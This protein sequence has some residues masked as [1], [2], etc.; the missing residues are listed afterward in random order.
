MSYLFAL[1]C[2]A[3]VIALDQLS[4]YWIVLQYGNTQNYTSV[5]GGLINI[6]HVENSGAAWSILAGR[7]W[8]LVSISL[9]VMVIC[10]F[11]LVKKTF[12]SKWMFWAVS[13]ILGGGIGNLIDRIFRG[14]RVVDFIEFGF[15]DFPVFN[16]ADI[17]V[18][19]GAIMILGA[20]VV[21]II[22][23]GKKKKAGKTE[24]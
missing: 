18:T 13:L 20:F 10:V 24:S 2:S 22:R 11:M 17:A 15:V 7:T 14:G 5:L 21:D 6:R 19:T 8:L 1:L 12:G 16:V 9:A 23:D 4:K 3:G